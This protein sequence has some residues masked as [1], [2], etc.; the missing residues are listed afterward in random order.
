MLK[1]PS[2]FTR[3]P[4]HKR[5]SYTPRHYDAQEEERKEREQRIQR[6]LRAKVDEEISEGYRTRISGS[7]R[8][9]RKSQSK[10]FDPS[11]N[12]IRLFILTFLVVWIIA[13]LHYG[14]AAIYALLLF[15]PFYLWLKFIRKA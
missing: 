12:L 1:L 9:S 14:S 15:V 11:A 5:F 7:F 4:K 3:I 10:P 2:I 8:T 6:E 13:Y